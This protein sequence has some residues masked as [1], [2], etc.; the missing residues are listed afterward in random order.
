MSFTRFF[1]KA[2][3]GTGVTAACA[4]IGMV[5]G[6]V[7][8]TAGALVRNIFGSVDNDIAIAGLSGMLGVGTLAIPEG[9]LIAIL[10]ISGYLGTAEDMRNRGYEK[11]LQRL[12]GYVGYTANQV[13]GG[14]IGAALMLRILSLAL[15]HFNNM[16]ADV[17]LGAAITGLLI[18][19]LV[20]E[21]TVKMAD[22]AYRA[23]NEAEARPLLT[24]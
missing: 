9:A 3:I 4:V 24:M 23:T 7:S 11:P 1:K 22:A 21:A 2:V 17:A 8:G 18:T 19:P 10:A 20:T 14:A 13:A 15:P 12:F 6:A 5:E 16:V